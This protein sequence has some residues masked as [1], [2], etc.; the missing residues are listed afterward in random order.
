M[1][2]KNILIAGAAAALF[3]SGA[4]VAQADQKAGAD[5]VRCAGVNACKGQGGCA[6]A[7]NACKGQNGCKGEGITMMSADDCKTKGGTVA[8]EKQ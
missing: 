1:N 4:V 3:L 5:Q 6:T 2:P 8:P 7:H